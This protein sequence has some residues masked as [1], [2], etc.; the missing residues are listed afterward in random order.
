LYEYEEKVNTTID[1][2]EEKKFNFVELYPS[3]KQRGR[4]TTHIERDRR[5]VELRGVVLMTPVTVVK[6]VLIAWLLHKSV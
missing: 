2:Q 5:E 1:Q 4:R 6:I 3:A